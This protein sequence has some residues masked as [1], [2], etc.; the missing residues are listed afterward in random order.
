MLILGGTGWLGRAAAAAAV[1]AGHDLTCLARGAEVARGASSVRADR[2]RD[3]A[4]AGVAGSRW[5]AV[6][7]VATQPG[8]VRRAVRDLEAA[9][10]RYLY[11]SSCNAYASLADPGI[12]ESAELNAP[13]EAD[14]LASLDDYGAAKV[15]CEQAVLAGFGAARTVV[16]R[17]ALI[18]GPG[19]PTGR[20]SYWPLRFAQPSNPEGRVLV[21]GAVADDAGPAVVS[22]QPTSLIDVR[23]LAAWILH[24]IDSAGSGI[25]NAAGEPIPM[26]EHVRLARRVAGHDGRMVP[27]APAGL[28]AH[29]VAQWSGPRSLPLWIEEAEARGINQLSNARARAAGLR[30]RPLAETL[31]DT[32][33]WGVQQRIDIANGAGLRDDEERE[34]LALAETGA[35]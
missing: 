22:E 15:A 19:D 29:G 14:E 30:L 26:R 24:L 35:L 32:L 3:D 12:D 8:H 16:V 11:I 13:L 1:A 7:D 10:E 34:L 4:L 31:A 17:P 5:D 23:D 28:L 2:D 21:P 33:A 9:A 25:F 27:A 18:G 6:V 20:S